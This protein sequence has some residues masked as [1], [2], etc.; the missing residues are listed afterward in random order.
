[1]AED[2]T[3][4][5]FIKLVRRIQRIQPEKGV[6]GWLYRVARNRT[7]DILRR[8]KRLWLPAGTFFRRCADRAA[9]SRGVPGEQMQKTEE[10]DQLARLL[11]SLPRRE[12]E[13]LV[14]HY[15]GDLTF[16]EVAATLR[17]PLGTVLY[18]ARRGIRKLRALYGSLEP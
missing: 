5:C 2:I 7:L 14:M 1:M 9:S 15:F 18:Q 13:V 12:R 8:R 6:S 16:R 11:D 3:Q 4:E 10:A 17:R